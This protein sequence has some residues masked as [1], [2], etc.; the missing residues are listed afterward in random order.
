MRSH[1]IDFVQITYNAADREVER[2]ILPLAVDRGIAV[3]VNRPF[4]QGELTDA[5]RRR[6]LP[7][8]ARE[9]DSTSWAQLLLKFIVSHRA[10]TCAIP[11][12]T[13]VAHVRENLVAAT[14]R[15]PDES[16]RLRIAAEVARL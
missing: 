14:G 11:A 15:M 5:L 2:R 16:L 13:S 7:Q 3:I 4:R 10:V 1:R 8:W 6:P 9:V 12:T